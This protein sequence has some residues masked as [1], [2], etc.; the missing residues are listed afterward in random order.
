MS[1]NFQASTSPAASP[2]PGSSQKSRSLKKRKKILTILY[3]DPTYRQVS[4]FNVPGSDLHPW[5]WED[6]LQ[7][8]LEDHSSKFSDLLN[9]NSCKFN[10]PHNNNSCNSLPSSRN[11]DSWWDNDFS[12][13]SSSCR[14]T[15]SVAKLDLLFRETWFPRDGWS[16]KGACLEL[17][18][19][20]S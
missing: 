14:Q 6:Q 2:Y 12:S 13:S 9:N 3:N 20:S 15:V 19:T 17:V 18:L 4:V 10:V 16:F 5:P 1:L 11:N 7:S 8:K